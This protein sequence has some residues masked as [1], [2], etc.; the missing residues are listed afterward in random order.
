MRFGHRPM[1]SSALVVALV[2]MAQPAAAQQAALLDALNAYRSEPR[3]CAGETYEALPPLTA[4]ARLS[5]PAG[6]DLQ[7]ALSASG[8][9]YADVRAISLSGPRDAQSAMRALRDSYCQVLLDPQFVDAGVTQN[10]RDWRIILARPL[11]SAKLGDSPAEGQ[12][13]LELINRARGQARQCGEQSMAAAGPLTWNDTLAAVALGHSRAMASQ[14]L[15]SHRDRDGYT[16]ADRAELGGY[17]G[18][19]IGENL[20]AGLDQ[21]QKV[22]DGWLNSPSHCATLM[23][24]QFSELGAGYAIDPNSDA[25][26]YWTGLFGTP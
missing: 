18:R 15:F 7:Q 12:R 25:G 1:S 9:T 8:Y 11:I 2:A 6:G 13:L 3:A 4:D 20:A 21:P 5:L 19:L 17:V 23:N 14:N 16:P 22:L 24:P 10:G 26:I